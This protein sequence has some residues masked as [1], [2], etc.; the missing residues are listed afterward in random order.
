VK[1]DETYIGG[2][3]PGRNG[4]GVGKTGVAIAAL[5]RRRAPIVMEVRRSDANIRML[6]LFFDRDLRAIYD[7]PYKLVES[8]TGA[9]ELFDLERAKGEYENLVDHRPDISRSLEAC[10]E[11]IAEDR[12]PLFDVEDRAT[13]T[14]ETEEALRA[15][16]YVE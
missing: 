6:G 10:L 15:L 13:L 7:P 12:P 3:R 14:P 16:G 9:V 4:R 8:S 2:Y 5:S 11:R 1:A